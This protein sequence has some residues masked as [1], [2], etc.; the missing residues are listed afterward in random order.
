MDPSSENPTTGEEAPP[1]PAPAMPPRT[2]ATGM[3]VSDTTT[4]TTQSY[5]STMKSKGGLARL[6]RA[7]SY[8]RDGLKE[9]FLHEHAFRQELFVIVPLLFAAAILPARLLEKALL[10]GS[11]LLILVVELL[12]SAIESCI[13]YISTDR[14]PLAKRAKDMGSAAVSIAILQAALIWLAIL[15]PKL[16]AS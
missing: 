1:T 9:A 11:L 13:D 16:S 10:A 3:G 4:A 2:F 7:C 6:W 5:G 12:N 15:I 14:H 8:S